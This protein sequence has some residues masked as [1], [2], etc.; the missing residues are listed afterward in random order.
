MFER[1]PEWI[2]RSPRIRKIIVEIWRAFLRVQR[3]TVARAVLVAT[4]HD[5]SVLV[6]A[7]PAGELRLPCFELDGWQPVEAQVRTW[8]NAM[9]ANPVNLKLKAIDGVPGLEGVKVL[10]SAEMQGTSNEIGE[11]WLDTEQ[12][13]SAL[14]VDDRRLLLISKN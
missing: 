5:D 11:T 1:A 4:R 8:I 3:S 14:H 12:A 9:T 6:V 13:P 2:S 7:T 10:Y